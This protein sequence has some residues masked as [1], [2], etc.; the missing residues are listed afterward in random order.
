FAAAMPPICR[1]AA[2]D[3]SEPAH[4]IETFLSAT[5]DALVRRAVSD[6]PFF[7]RVHERAAAPGATPEVRWLSALLGPTRAMRHED[8]EADHDGKAAFAQQ[9][10]AWLGQLDDSQAA[11]LRLCFILDEPEE[12]P[13]S[14]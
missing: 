2:P 9:A 14:S 8:E 11:A 13:E 12:L 5:T 10:Q 6:D 7:H 1:A 4:L 3:A